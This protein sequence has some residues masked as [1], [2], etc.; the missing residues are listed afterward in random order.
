M[1]ESKV[2]IKIEAYEDNNF[3]KPSSDKPSEFVVDINPEK[4][5]HQKSIQMNSGKQPQGG[6]EQSQHQSYA[7]DQLSFDVLIDGT[8]V[9]NEVG[10][11]TKLDV[12]NKVKELIHVL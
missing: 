11:T 12:N 4:I 2:K 10:N 1:S 8:G 7:A 9:F 3:S 6:G 5:T